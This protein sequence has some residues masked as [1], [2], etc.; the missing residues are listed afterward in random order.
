MRANI[1]FRPMPSDERLNVVD[2]TGAVIGEETREAIHQQGLL[3]RD[4]H[5]WFV[6]PEHELIVQH[7]SPST[8]TFR[9]LLDATV[10]GH[11][12]IGSTDRETALREIK[13]E[14]GLDA[15][16]DDLLFIETM[17][18]KTHD[19]T[20]GITNHVLRSIFTCRYPGD[21]KQ[22]KI[23]KEKAVGFELWPIPKLLTLPPKKQKRFA[24]TLFDDAYQQ[25]FR[26]L[27]QL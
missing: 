23:E 1:S 17:I 15:R 10:G 3:H 4:V 19:P 11:V 16:P 5:V 18:S 20:T 6:T 21:V 13:E 12:E 22:L 2:E 9:G 27:Q 25:I 14:T 7:R 24:P 8:D 26:K